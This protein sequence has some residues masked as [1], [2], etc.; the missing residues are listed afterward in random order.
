MLNG[1]GRARTLVGETGQDEVTDI[2]V[3]GLLATRDVTM[4]AVGV[5]RGLHRGAADTAEIQVRSEIAP[6]VTAPVLLARGV[7]E[8]VL[9]GQPRLLVDDGAMLGAHLPDAMLVEED[10]IAPVMEKA[11]RLRYLRIWVLLP[12]LFI[13]LRISLFSL[14]ILLASASGTCTA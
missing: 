6:V 12:F 2:L 1:R 10:V 3:N 7:V 4:A 8:D 14:R 11:L 13:F 9:D 5:R